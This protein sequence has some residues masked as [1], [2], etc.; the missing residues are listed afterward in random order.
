MAVFS[1]TSLRPSSTR[2]CTRRVC[3]VSGP[4]SAAVVDAAAPDPIAFRRHVH[5]L[6]LP[7]D[8]K[9]CGTAR[10]SV[11]APHTDAD[12]HTCSTATA[13]LPGLLHSHGYSPAIQ[14]SCQFSDP[15]FH[16]SGLGGQ[17]PLLEF[18]LS[19]SSANTTRTLHRPNTGQGMSP[20]PAANATAA[21]SPPQ[22]KYLRGN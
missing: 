17:H 13:A 8:R 9:S 15:R 6:S 4:S 3:P 11:A 10:S 1:L 20:G 12:A 18:A 19:F 14:T 7:K 2:F 22:R 16:C 5:R 21:F